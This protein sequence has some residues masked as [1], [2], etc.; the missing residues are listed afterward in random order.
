LIKLLVQETEP[1]IDA[2]G[3]KIGEIWK[4]QNLRIAYVAQH[5]FHHVE[6]HLDESPVDYFKWRFDRGVDKENLAKSTMVTTTEE[7]RE[8]KEKNNKF[9]DPDEILGRRKNGRSM[10]YECTWIGQTSRDPSKYFSTEELVERGFAKLIAAADAK[11]ASIAAGLD[12]RPLL[13]KEIQTHLDDFNLEAEYGTHS[14]IRRLSG[15]QKV[16][17]V[18]AAAMWNKPHCIVLDEPTNYL[19]REALGALTQAIKNFAGGVVIISHNKEFT[20]A[21]C[22]EVW[23]VKNG[24]VSVA[25]DVEESKLQV[26]AAKTKNSTKLEENKILEADQGEIT[27]SGA[28]NVNSTK[29]FSKVTELIKNPKTLDFLTKVE[30]RKLTK[31]AQVAGLPLKDYVAKLN[32]NS[33]E[34]KWL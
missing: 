9:G 1:D 33:P 31:L 3:N 15:G 13:T 16:K 21:L 27:S 22:T 23:N 24:I 4:H 2:N 34:W 11:I 8:R 14:N 25:G 26:K 17:L 10:E 6:Q 12:L 28:G 5:S 20:D 19:D 29:D 18:L 32:K 7:D 30:I